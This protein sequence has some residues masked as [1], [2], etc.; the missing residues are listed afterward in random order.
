[1]PF[2]RSLA[3]KRRTKLIFTIISLSEIM[4]S[5]SRYVKKSYYTLRSRL[6]LITNHLFMLSIF[7][8]IYGRPIIYI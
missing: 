7:K 2:I 1:M 4:P 8:Q 3:S 6:Y 5:Y